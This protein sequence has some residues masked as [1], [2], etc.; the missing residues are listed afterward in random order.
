MKK[1]EAVTVRLDAEVYDKLKQ[2]C[3]EQHMSMTGAI[4]QWIM[5]SKVVNS[6]H[7]N[8]QTFDDL[9]D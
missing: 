2:Y 5:A 8:Q 3:F 9:E 1:K 6:V 4:T 7:W